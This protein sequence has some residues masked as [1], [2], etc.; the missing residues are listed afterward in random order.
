MKTF[1]A[2][3]SPL[4][5]VCLLSFAGF[6]TLSAAFFEDDFEGDLSLWTGKTGTPHSGEIVADP[7]DSRNHVLR[8]TQTAQGGD[9]FSKTVFDQAKVIYRVSFRYLGLEHPLVIA[10]AKRGAAPLP[11]GPLG[12]FVGLAEEFPGAHNWIF[13]TTTDG[14]ADAHLVD[15]GQWHTYSFQFRTPV[16]LDFQTPTGEVVQAPSVRLMLQDFIGS[17]HAGDAYFDDIKVEN[18]GVLPPFDGENPDSFDPDA[19][20]KAPAVPFDDPAPGTVKR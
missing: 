17:E 20:G 11:G 12:G 10:P 18:A 1:T 9:I 15:D 2:L 5:A 3:R 6:S 7:F 8:F 16:P 4:A 14:Q 19:G 13:G